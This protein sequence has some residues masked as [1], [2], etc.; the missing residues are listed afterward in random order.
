MKTGKYL[1]II[2]LALIG[3]IGCNQ[4][5]TNKTSQ[6]S[7]STKDTRPNIIFIFA[8][9]WGYGDLG[10]HGNKDFK[11]PHLDKMAKEGID[12]QSFT[13][14]HP[15][16]SPSRTAVMT[17]QFPA[18]NSIH[19]HFSTVPRHE[20]SGMPD[21]LNPNALMMPRL[22]QEAGYTTGH[23]GKWH[24]SNRAVPDMPPPTNYGYNEFG[25][26]NLAGE[27]ILESE[28]CGK[29]VEFIKKNKDKPFFINVW[30]HETHL[31]HY[32]EKKYMDQ[33]SHLDEQKQVYAAV[34]AGGD[35][36]VGMILQTLKDL[37]LDENTLVI[38]SSDNGPE[39]T[40][41]IKAKK[42]SRGREGALGAYYSVGTT[43]GLKGRKRSLFAG[44]VRV[45]FI[46]RWPGHVAEG[47][48]D[49]T[50][51]LT[52]VDLLP[53]FMEIAGVDLPQDFQPDGESVL[54]AFEQKN[55]KREKPIYWEWKGHNRG[56]Y[57]W[58]SIG[59]RDGKWKL[60]TSKE[61]GKTELYD[62]ENDWAEKQDVSAENPEIVKELTEKVYAWKNTLPAEADTTCFSKKRK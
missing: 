59:I 9:D 58:A 19:A 49:T 53:T 55:F 4:K 57:M 5:T 23:F 34:L 24:L 16:C 18:R 43:A 38:F 41:T 10:V 26:F 13:V 31:P 52:A 47:I 29:T 2:T 6:E 44:G 15:V 37:N 25:C 32:P 61:L 48:L 62:I 56:E 60:L 33:F 17:G 51:V 8:D 21:W 45:P 3:S 27:E 30:M 1:L 46:V 54:A 28:T 35:A 50:S 22:L 36:G 14:N 12:F 11:T 42:M 7:S 20:K 39:S 40:G